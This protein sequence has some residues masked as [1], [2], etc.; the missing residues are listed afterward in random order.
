MG[1][2]GLEA[3]HKVYTHENLDWV[4]VQWNNMAV[5]EYKYVEIAKIQDTQKFY[6]SKIKA[7]IRC[8]YSEDLFQDHR[9]LIIEVMS[10]HKLL[11]Y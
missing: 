3:I 11:S 1:F 2:R 4:L 7:Y 8:T 5:Y 9:I 6:P 10:I